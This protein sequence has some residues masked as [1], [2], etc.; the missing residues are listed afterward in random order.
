MVD[1]RKI[2]V[3][4]EVTVRAKVVAL[5]PNKLCPEPIRIHGGSWINEK[6]ILTHTPAPREFKPGD[7]VSFYDMREDK[8]SYGV[9]VAIDEDFAW[10]KVPESPTPAGNIRV[11]L[12]ISELRHADERE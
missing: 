7:R 9:V 8:I 4:D 2:R 3:G 1:L 5:E 10:V 6:D 11:T 12:N